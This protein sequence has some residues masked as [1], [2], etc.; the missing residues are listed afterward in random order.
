MKNIEEKILMAEEEIKQLQ[1]KRKKLI[2]QQK[3]EERKKRDRRLYEKGAVFESIIKESI[4]FSKDDYSQLLIYAKSLNGFM[5]KVSELSKKA[6]EK[7]M[8]EEVKT[9]ETKSEG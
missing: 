7:P 4:S 9:E 3:Q 8:S 1:N 2:S 5:Q 6:T